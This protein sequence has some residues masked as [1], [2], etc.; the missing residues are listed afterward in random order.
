MPQQ[1]TTHSRIDDR[2][3]TQLT[4]GQR[5]QQLEVEGYV[6]LP[7]RLGTDHIRRL[8]KQTPLFETIH[9]DYSVHQRSTADCRDHHCRGFT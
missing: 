7:D 9:T 2:D 1:P 8:K 6:I 3:W 5:I 4:L